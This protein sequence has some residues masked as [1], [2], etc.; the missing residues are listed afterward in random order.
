MSRRIALSAGHASVAGKDRGAASGDH[1][2]GNLAEDLKLRV[3]H[4]LALMGVKCSIDPPDSVTKDTVALFKKYFKGNDICLDIHFNSSVKPEAYGT[5]C[6]IP[7]SYTDFEQDLATALCTYVSAALN[8]RN[9]GIITEL[10]TYRKK[11]MWM[12][13]PAE[14]VLLEVCFVSN[15][16]DMAKYEQRKDE[17]AQAI[18]SVL[19]Q[20]RNF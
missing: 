19:Y 5:E 10:Q 6:V 16:G 13:I 2:E 1:I 14:N 15:K 3:K 8:T 4:H 20:Y 11:L 17:V 9:R 18:A 7:A 12:T